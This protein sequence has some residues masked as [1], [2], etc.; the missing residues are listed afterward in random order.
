VPTAEGE[1]PATDRGPADDPTGIRRALTERW[2]LIAALVVFLAMSASRLRTRSLWVDEAIT[3]GAVGDL[4]R[5]LRETGGTMGLYYVVVAPVAALTHDRGW[6]RLPS[7]IAVAAA[8]WVTWEVGRRLGGRRVAGLAAGFVA[9]S[10]FAIRFGTEARGYG[11]A[12][13]LS[14][15]S[16]LGLVGAVGARSDLA[17]PSAR[18]D[19]SS[20][21]ADGARQERQWWALFAVASVLA[22]LAHG[23]SALQ[24]VVQG[25]SLLLLP[26]RVHWLRRFAP[27]AAAVGAVMVVLFGLGA[28]EVADWVPPLN[29][30]HL[31]NIVR[32]LLGS[33]GV[34]QLLVATVVVAGVV[35]ALV[36]AVRAH[37]RD[38]WRAAVPVLWALGLPVLLILLSL[39][40]PYG[41]YRYVLTSLPGIA[42]LVATAI[43]RL[44]RRWMVA[45]AAVVVAL[46]L[47]SERGAA[48]SS[49]DEPWS[50]L[51]DD[52]A[53]RMEPGDALVTTTAA[54]PAFDVA[55]A[56]DPRPTDPVPLHPGG[57]IGEVRRFYDEGGHPSPRDALLDGGADRVWYVD[58]GHT[59]RDEVDALLTDPEV[60]ERYRVVDRRTFGASLYLV[61]LEARGPTP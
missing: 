57:R 48:I 1:P 37:G 10:W 13:L 58:R 36:A 49:T 27:V 35:V 50:R 42:L 21:A 45:V 56:E 40:R 31:Q 2:A 19:A 25:A 7:L 4:G 23:V 20:E 24:L 41:V 60:L 5:T 54:R 38:R 34:P 26:D 8:V 16:W 55:W 30:G 11:L 39:V 9:L 53:A 14:S 51:A 44:P 6:L 18:A 59:R 46:A 61:E 52:M 3:L 32:A 33:D 28:G 22:P 29:N 47:W 17:G 12:L 15:L 43:D